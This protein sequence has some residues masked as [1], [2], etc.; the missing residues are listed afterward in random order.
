MKILYQ[1]FDELFGHRINSVVVYNTVDREEILQKAEKLLDQKPEHP[2]VVSLGRLAEPKN[3]IRMLKAHKKLID[4]GVWHRLTILGEGPQRELL[5]SFIHENHIDQTVSLLGFVENPY[6]WMKEA[7]ILACSSVYECFSTFV[8]EALI[9]GKPVVTTDVSG[10]RE[11]L[12]DSLY[13]L[14]TDNEDDAFYLGLKQLLCDSRLRDKYAE[15][16]KARG[17]DFSTENLVRETE[18]FLENA[19]R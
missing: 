2:L 17:M 8:T 14:I 11:L 5:E 10:M 4:E 9:L 15:K 6:P 18:M 16:A 19:V 7:D 13:G 12:G 1:K 3:Y